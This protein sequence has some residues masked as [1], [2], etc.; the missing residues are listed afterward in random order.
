[1]NEQR[2]AFSAIPTICATISANRLRVIMKPVL[3]LFWQI[4]LL[5]SGPEQVPTANWFI[6]AVIILNLLCSAALSLSLDTTGDVMS[7]I[8]RL[9][10][11][12]ATN[13]ALLWLVLYLRELSPRFPATVTALFGCDLIITLCFGALVPLVNALGDGG[14][15]FIFLGFLIWSV[16]VAGFIVHRAMNV[17]LGIGIFIAVSMMILSVATSEVA[18]NPI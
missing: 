12:Q 14:S 17:T 5:R 10:V 16:A 3:A 13:A 9:V 15:S 6:G 8:T 1:V 11:T 2:R 7:I 18:V 4:C